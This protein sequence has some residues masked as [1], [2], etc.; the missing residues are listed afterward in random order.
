MIDVASRMLDWEHMIRA[1]EKASP[2]HKPGTRTGYHGLTYGFIIGEIIQRV[3]GR[4]FADLVQSEIAE[5]L[6]LDGLYIGAPRVELPRAAQLIAARLPT[7]LAVWQVSNI[8]I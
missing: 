3:S 4:K 1:I 2:A 5:P 7:R 6:A 8:H